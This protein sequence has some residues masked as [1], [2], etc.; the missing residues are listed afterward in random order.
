MMMIE[1]EQRVEEV[2][3]PKKYSSEAYMAILN[4]QATT[5]KVATEC[6][7]YARGPLDKVRRNSSPLLVHPCFKKKE[8]QVGKWTVA[9]AVHY[10]EPESFDPKILQ[11]RISLGLNNTPPLKC[12]AESVGEQALKPL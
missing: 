4:K 9:L 10:M 1:L 12:V 11:V 7:M 3:I 2:E 6:E 8:D 5:D